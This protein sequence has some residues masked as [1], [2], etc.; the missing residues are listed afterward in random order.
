MRRGSLRN[1]PWAAFALVLAALLGGWWSWRRAASPELPSP[2][3]VVVYQNPRCGC[4]GVYVGY[5]RG[6]GYAVEVV[7]TEDMEGVKRRYRVPRPLWSCHTAVVG[8]Y[9]VEGHVPAEAVQELLRRAPDGLGIALPGMPS[10][11]PG[12]PGLRQGS[13][14]VYAVTS[15]GTW[16]EF[17]RF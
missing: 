11:S 8:R 7:R 2:A 12:M 15:A 6:A 5:L 13:F 3:R 10:G 14:V 1:V 4:C 17:G 9:F 16:R